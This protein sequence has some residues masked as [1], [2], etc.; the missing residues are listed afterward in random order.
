VQAIVLFLMTVGDHTVHAAL[1]AV[2]VMVRFLPTVG[3]ETFHD[4]LTAVPL[5]KPAAVTP[6]HDR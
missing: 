2:S 1:H 6:L 3:A 5:E 4:A